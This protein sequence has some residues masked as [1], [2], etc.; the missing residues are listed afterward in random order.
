MRLYVS[1][2]PLSGKPVFKWVLPAED[3]DRY[4]LSVFFQAPIFSF[5][6]GGPIPSPSPTSL[7]DSTAR[8]F[9]VKRGRCGEGVAFSGSEALT[10]ST[11]MYSRDPSC[12]LSGT[13]ALVDTYKQRA[14]SLPSVLVHC[15]A[16]MHRS[17]GMATAFLLWLLRQCRTMEAF[18]GT[19]ISRVH[20]QTP[21]L[22][23]AGHG[24]P[25]PSATLQYCMALVKRQRVIAE[26]IPTVAFLLAHFAV[27]LQLE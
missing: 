21:H 1:V 4:N 9:A 18:L 13:P 5:L 14:N 27:R 25:P 17:C 10:Y 22:T 8:S 26:P 11:G 3:S 2:L 7:F 19:T 15:S 12:S 6:Q 20:P 24:G 16:G 23:S